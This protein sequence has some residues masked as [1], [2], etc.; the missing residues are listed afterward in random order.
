MVSSNNTSLQYIPYDLLPSVTD[1]ALQTSS[2][3]LYTFWSMFTSFFFITLYFYW[4]RRDLHPIKSRMPLIC[5][6]S[7]LSGWLAI[8][9]HAFED[10][11]VGS[12]RWSCWLRHWTIWVVIPFTF[13]AFP[14]RAFRLFMVSRLANYMAS[15]QDR[16]EQITQSRPTSSRVPKMNNNPMSSK[17]PSEEEKEIEMMNRLSSSSTF[18]PPS[19]NHNTTTTTTNI[20]PLCF[21]LYACCVYSQNSHQAH[22]TTIR[23]HIRKIYQYA[24]CIVFTFI[25]IAVI[26]HVLDI[27]HSKYGCYGSSMGT[28]IGQSI[29]LL[30]IMLL[31]L[32]FILWTYI[33][34]IN[35]NFSI[36]T[37]LKIVTILKFF[38][39]VPYLI[40]HFLTYNN[41]NINILSPSVVLPT[42]AQVTSKQLEKLSIK[43]TC[44]W[45]VLSHWCVFAWVL[46]SYIISIVVPLIA[47]ILI[48][49]SELRDQNTDVNKKIKKRTSQMLLSLTKLLNFEN[50]RIA[51]LNFLKREYSMENLLFYEACESYIEKVRIIETMNGNG[52]TSNYI[53]SRSNAMF[54]EAKSIYKKF[55]E[56]NVA[57]FEINLPNHIRKPLMKIFNDDN[58]S[59][60][61]KMDIEFI[62]IFDKAMDNIFHLM[63]TDSFSRF[64][65]S[66]E[67]IKLEKNNHKT[68]AWR[69]SMIEAH[70]T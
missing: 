8:T 42:D 25:L 39:I 17:S 50:G 56:P 21:S 28:S 30:F 20:T 59:T 33:N 4:R 64:K 43:I 6:F 67:A 44:V 52:N 57:P 45:T 41:C 3:L 24:L 26:T 51:F 38:L 29:I 69:N 49:E 65:K 19:N 61:N 2:L 13:V 35:G 31:E 70:M 18:S 68:A 54:E 27:N 36:I 66:A 62:S 37:E 23:G 46:I 10:F 16:H 60:L 1:S 40:L 48:G 9:L 63:E 11:L 58:L 12:L 7:A 5:A 55:V 14:L 32:L 53:D 22:V 15:I 34:Q 47:S